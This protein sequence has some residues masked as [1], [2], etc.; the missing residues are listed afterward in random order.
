LNFITHLCGKLPAGPPEAHPAA[1][2]PQRSEDSRG[3]DK[4]PRLRGERRVRQS[5]CAFGPA[6]LRLCV[7]KC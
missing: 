7:A 2:I 6:G 3:A 1:R 5:T 4:P